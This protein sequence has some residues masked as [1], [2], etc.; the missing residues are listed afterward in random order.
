M[1]PWALLGAAAL[2]G[3]IGNIGDSGG[4]GTSPLGSDDGG[5]IPPAGSPACLEASVGPGPLRRLTAS[6]LRATIADLVGADLITDPLQPDSRVGEFRSNADAPTQWT[7]ALDLRAIAETVAAHV[8]DDA[9]A[10]LDCDVASLGGADDEAACVDAFLDD[11]GRRAFRRPLGGDERA[12]YQAFFAG[13]REDLDLGFVGATRMLVEAMLQSPGFAYHLERGDGDAATV[14]DGRAP[15]TAWELAS[16]LSY[17][18]WGSMPDA[19]LFDAAASGALLEDEALGAQIDR[20]LADERGQAHLRSF[21]SQWLALESV[22]SLLKSEEMFPEFDA[23][24]RA[25]MQASTEAL[26]A[27]VLWSGDARLGTLLTSPTQF[28]DARLAELLEVPGTFGDTLQAVEIEGGRRPGILSHPSILAFTSHPDQTS[29]VHRGLFVRSRLLCDEPPPPPPEL[30]VQPL[31]LD[32]T[33]TTRERLELTHVSPDCAGCHSLIDPVGFGMEKYDAIGRHR[34]IENGKPIDDSG[35][36]SS[37]DVDGEFVGL[38]E[39]VARLAGSAELSRCTEKQ[40]M[41][42]ALGRSVDGDEVCTL[43]DALVEAAPADLDLLALMRAIAL[44]D[45]FR[46]VRVDDAN[47]CE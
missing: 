32:P 28:V 8:A 27:D 43:G 13:V 22:P 38:G 23:E 3:C 47:A 21:F 6:E 9:G 17:F 12:R 40:A 10:Y 11:F 24:L 2:A 7:N 34:S 25:S 29:P 15:L 42:F 19:E 4:D 36:L 18:L 16:R 14:G 30:V 1:M 44:S 35:T 46:S 37:T 5:M 33:L 31:P 39:L 45:A 26:I 20:L 41:T